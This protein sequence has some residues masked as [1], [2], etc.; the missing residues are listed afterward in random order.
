[1]SHDADAAALPDDQA[2][3]GRR[4][5]GC[6]DEQMPPVVMSIRLRADASDQ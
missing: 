4:E 1:M 2:R 6:V 3:A 5:A